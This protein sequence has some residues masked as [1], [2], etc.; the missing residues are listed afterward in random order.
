MATI[1]E[2][3]QT[4]VDHK[5]AIKAALE[6]QG[7]EPTEALGTYAGLIDTLENPDEVSYCVTVDGENKAFA[8]LYGQERVTLTATANDIRQN[9]S[10]ITDTGYTEGTKD[11]PAYHTQEGRKVVLAGNDLSL[12][13]TDYDYTYLQIIVTKLA[14]SIG[15]SI[16]AYAVVINDA[17]YKTNSTTKLADITKDDN[18]QTINLGITAEENTVLRYFTMR[19]ES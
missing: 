7:K 17:V 9:T 2:N 14:A 10:A 18:T 3:L 8:Q 19:E 4:L 16:E 11:I 15:E 6:N 1:A 12:T 5:A 13:L